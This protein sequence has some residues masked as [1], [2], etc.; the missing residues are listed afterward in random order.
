MVPADI[1][2]PRD[3]F[4][5]WL[6]R[7]RVGRPDETWPSG[8]AGSLAP[9]CQ[10]NVV[11]LPERPEVLRGI[12]FVAVF[13]RGVEGAVRAYP[14]LADL[15]PWTEVERAAEPKPIR[16]EPLLDDG[17]EER[18]DRVG[19]PTGFVLEVAGFTVT[20]SGEEWEL[21]AAGG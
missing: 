8:A 11:E 9:L 7:V 13:G 3:P 2:P 1:R 4:A 10:L 20:R 15:I 21:V 18:G 6:G 12:A 19:G 16:W 17:G 14:S 5:S